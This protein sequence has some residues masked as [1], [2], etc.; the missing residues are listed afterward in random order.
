MGQNNGRSPWLKFATGVVSGKYKNIDVML[1]AIKAMMVKAD[2]LAAG[3]TL[4]NM[5]YDGAFSDFCNFVQC[6]SSAAYK[7]LRRHFGGPWSR[8]I[9]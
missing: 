1:G 5:T 4:S 2:R 9:R 3:K 7:T 8:S 6:Q